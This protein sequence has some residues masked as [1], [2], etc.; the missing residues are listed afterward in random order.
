MGGNENDWFGGNPDQ[1]ISN[2]L[3][4]GKCKE[5]IVVIP[6]IKARHDSVK[7]VSYTHL[8]QYATEKQW[9][10]LQLRVY[11]GANGSFAVSYTHLIKA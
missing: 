8:V 10:H 7:A 3:H 1:I 4:E 5:M 11:T 6:N 9:D 2:L